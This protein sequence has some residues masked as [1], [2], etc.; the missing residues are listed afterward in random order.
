MMHSKISSL[1]S[2]FMLASG[3]MANSFYVLCGGKLGLWKYIHYLL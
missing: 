1:M 3:E 2:F